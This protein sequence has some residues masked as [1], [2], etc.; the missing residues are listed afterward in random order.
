M[1]DA[2]N[3]KRLRDAAEQ[4]YVALS[5]AAAMVFRDAWH[6]A[7]AA[8]RADDADAGLNLAASALSRLITIYGLDDVSNARTPIALDVAKGR[9]IEG[10]TS[11]RLHE[12]PG[13]RITSLSVRRSELASALSFITRVGLPVDPMGAFSRKDAGAGAK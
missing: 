10:A 1:M 8:E 4:Q 9:F 5:A 11:F 2:T 7:P 3:D 6:G 12:C 13:L